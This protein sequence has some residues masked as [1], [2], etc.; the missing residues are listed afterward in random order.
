[1]A[2]KLPHDNTAEREQN[3]HYS[4]YNGL[5]TAF[6]DVF[7]DRRPDIASDKHL[8]FISNLST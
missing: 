4:H 2:S 8:Y 5:N 3:P 6:D 1:L 7:H